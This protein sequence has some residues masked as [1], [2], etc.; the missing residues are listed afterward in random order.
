ML[1]R[2]LAKAERLQQDGTTVMSWDANLQDMAAAMENG[3][4]DGRLFEAD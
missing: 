1:A 4:P 3:G 2:D